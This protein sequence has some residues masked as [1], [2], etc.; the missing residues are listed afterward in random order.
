MG[1]GLDVDG[2]DN[3]I[4]GFGIMEPKTKMPWRRHK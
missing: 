3:V 2:G 4:R 1:F